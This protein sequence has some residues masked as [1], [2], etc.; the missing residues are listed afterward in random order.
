MIFGV[1]HKTRD[2]A[3]LMVQ[4]QPT[5]AFTGAEADNPAGMLSVTVVC[6]WAPGVPQ[7]TLP[8]SDTLRVTV[9]VPGDWSGFGETPLLI[10]RSHCDATNGPMRAGLE[11]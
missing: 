9:P 11:V 5:G 2:P 10:V 3:F 6:T 8:T 1:E 4:L 7:S